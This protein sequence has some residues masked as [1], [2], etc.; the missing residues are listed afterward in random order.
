MTIDEKANIVIEL[1]SRSFDRHESIILI[2]FESILLFFL[3]LF[4]YNFYEHAEIH[5]W[6]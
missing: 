6:L 2:F 5:K 3:V 4:S 1:I